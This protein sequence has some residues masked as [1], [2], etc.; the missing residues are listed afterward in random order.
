LTSSQRASMSPP[1][2]PASVSR[3][4]VIAASVRPA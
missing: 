1:P 3:S 4:R 2:T